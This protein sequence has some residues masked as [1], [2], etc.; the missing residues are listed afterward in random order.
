VNESSR[1][2]QA[3]DVWPAEDEDWF[4]VRADQASVEEG[5][6]AVAA[7]F[8]FRLE[9]VVYRGLEVWNLPESEGLKG[10]RRRAHVYV[11]DGSVPKR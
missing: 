5:R 8:A 9:V 6:Q 2:F 1:A 4:A 10:R 3:V 11:T 7:K